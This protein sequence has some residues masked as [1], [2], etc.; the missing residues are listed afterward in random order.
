MGLFK[1]I[2]V[3]IQL[4]KPILSCWN[5]D[6]RNGGKCVPTLT[7]LPLDL[8]VWTQVYYCISY[9]QLINKYEKLA[10]V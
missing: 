3:A 2:V 5:E 9:L 7:K 10:T 4:H 6:S 8:I 1:E